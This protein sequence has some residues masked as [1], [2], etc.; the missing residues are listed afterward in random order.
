MRITN[1]STA[2]I[3][4]NFP[5][6]LVKIETD[7]G[8]TGLGEAYWGAGVAELVHR[9]KP[10][11]IGENPFNIGKLVR[12]DDPLS[13]GRRLTG[14]R[15][16]DR[17]QRDRDRAVGPGRPRAEDADLQ[18]LRRTVPRQGPHLCRLPCR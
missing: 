13:L 11:I 1:V 5:W 7:A 14:R 10:L 15:D 9:A 6:V 4:G 16:G 12:A 18:P 8:I 3:E 17:D 2:V